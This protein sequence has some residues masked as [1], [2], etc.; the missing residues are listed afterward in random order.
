MDDNDV[1]IASLVENIHRDDLTENEKQKT[2]EDIY[3]AAWEEWK[4]ENWKDI[5]PR[6]KNPSTGKIITYDLNSRVGRLVLAKQ[7]ASKV[8]VLESGHKYMNLN[9]TQLRARGG[10][11]KIETIKPTDA[12]KILRERIGYKA[13]TQ[14]YIL[15]GAGSGRRGVDPMNEMPAISR[16]KFEEDER[17]K[18]L[19]LERK[20][21]L[22]KKQR[23]AL[24]KAKTIK[25]K[26][27]KQIVDEVT[28]QYFKQQ[29]REKK[30]KQ[31]K[32]KQED[33]KEKV[34]TKQDESKPEQQQDFGP[35]PVVEEKPELEGN[36]VR[37]RQEIIRS[38]LKL[39]RTLTGEDLT[40]E[41][42][43]AGEIQAKSKHANDTMKE[44]ATFYIREG[45]LAN[46]QMAIIPMHEA[47][48][49]FI[50]LVYESIESEHK[51]DD[52]LRP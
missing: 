52:M 19:D 15:A 11:G 7:Y 18:V 45:E 17:I 38:C 2:L 5:M 20:K 27:K 28:N 12:F 49:R 43:H 36:P 9:A 22:A 30:A 32:Q 35:K 6:E 40:M 50:D 37:A 1:R 31:Q 24:T 23:A 34:S 8:A 39:F 44:I 48:G 26:S 33:V 16:K 41:S 42:I 51:K 21:E 4:P 25:K 10:G 29:E 13:G 46:L 14:R 3:I 47:L